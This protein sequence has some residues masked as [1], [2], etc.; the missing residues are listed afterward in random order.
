M[1]HRWLGEV[2][3]VFQVRN[4][5][6]PLYWCKDNVHWSLEGC[7]DIPQPER[8]PGKPWHAMMACLCCFRPV[9]LASFDLEVPWNI[10]QCREHCSLSQAADAFLSARDK[11]RVS[12]GDGVQVPEVDAEA[13][14]TASFGSDYK[15]SC[16]FRSRR[17]YD[18]LATTRPAFWAG[19]CPEV[20]P[21][22]YGAEWSGLALTLSI[23]MRGFA[24][25]ISPRYPFQ[26]LLNLVGISNKVGRCCSKSSGICSSLH[27]SYLRALWSLSFTLSYSGT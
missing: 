14:Q 5:K 15:W 16:P 26:M 21:V 12:E 3:D 8:Y 17:L 11:V 10:I 1:V 22:W 20:S 2:D 19:S 6:Q 24:T 13:E 9:E 23:S 27:Q 4:G 18:I 7:R 25:F